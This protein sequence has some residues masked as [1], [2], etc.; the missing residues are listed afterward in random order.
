MLVWPG[1]SMLF[2]NPRTPVIRERHGL[3]K[4]R[5]QSRLRHIKRRLYELRAPLAVAMICMIALAGHGCF[6]PPQD[7]RVDEIQRS[8]TRVAQELEATNRQISALTLILSATA[9]PQPKLT[10]DSSRTPTP[11]QVPIPTPGLTIEEVQA[12]I[13]AGLAAIPVSTPGSTLEDVRTAARQA[14]AEFLDAHPTPT[15]GPSLAEIEEAIGQSVATAIA[16]APAANSGLDEIRATL[17]EELREFAQSHPT[18]TPGPGMADVERLVQEAVIAG[19]ALLPARWIAS[20]SS[21]SSQTLLANDLL[22]TI[23]PAQPLAGRD[24]SFRLDGLEPWAMISVEFVDP[25]GEPAEWITS[26][27]IGFGYR[28][29]SPVTTQTLYAD[30]SGSIAWSRVGTKD[31]EGVW[32]VRLDMADDGLVGTY[33]LGQLQ[34]SMVEV[35]TSGLDMRRYQGLVSDVYVAAMVPSSFAIDSQAHLQWVIEHIWETYRVR[36]AR[37]P[38]VYLV[39]DR[40]NFELV[41]RSLGWEPGYEFGFYRPSVDRPAIFTRTDAFRSAILST[42]THEYVHLIVH[43]YANGA[44]VPAWINEG[45]AR[46]VE[47]GLGL[48]GERPNVTRHLLYSAVERVRAEA[49]AGNVINLTD[50]KSQQDWNSQTDE[51]AVSL[52][53]DTSY[54]AVK[55]MSE[56]YGQRA[57]FDVISNISGGSSLSAAVR[58]ALGVSYAEFQGQFEDWI[59]TWRDPEQEAVRA[60]VDRVAPLYTELRGEIDRR[61]STLDE[62]LSQSDRVATLND[63]LSQLVGFQDTLASIAPPAASMELHQEFASL[64][65]IAIEWVALEVEFENTRDEATRLA[66]ND[67]IPEVVARTWR[68]AR[69]LNDSRSIFLVGRRPG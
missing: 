18:P 37:I 45:L 46:H 11:T 4:S 2:L 43:E 34:L 68:V 41:A 29:G 44:S 27:E 1:L 28:N 7:P 9:T 8:N 24:V 26:H 3:G 55:L 19:I 38:D 25:R 36:S 17:Q 6:Q 69:L 48:S 56:G 66:A 33:P 54:M 63:V 21:A 59:G 12:A 62:G 40:A 60:Y 15:P 51:G 42:L 53:Y 13:S 57:P 58:D 49:A 47:Y 50:L 64:S 23:D 20:Q 65:D 52:Q 67:R 39:G 35:V 30:E 32:S 10:P 22:L 14:M 5:G 31:V 16:A 61:R